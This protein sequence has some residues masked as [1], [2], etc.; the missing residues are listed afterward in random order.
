LSARVLLQR[1]GGGDLDAVVGADAAV[2]PGQGEVEVVAGAPR[3]E[4]VAEV[5]EDELA[6]EAE[7]GEAIDDG[8]FVVEREG[9]AGGGVGREG[10]G[11]TAFVEPVD[12]EATLAGD[13]VH[14]HGAAHAGGIAPEV[15][16]ALVEGA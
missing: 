16:V 1:L 12:D 9:L 7:R 4:L 10:R 8:E 14:G 15:D 2:L 11:E 13:A 5:F 6:G 3:D